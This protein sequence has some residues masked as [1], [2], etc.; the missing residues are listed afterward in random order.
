[1]PNKD[2]ILYLDMDGVLVDFEGGYQRA[3]KGKTFSQ[4]MSKSSE[5]SAQEVYYQRGVHFWSNLD[6]IQ[7]GK[8]LYAAAK[9]LFERVCILSSGGTQDPLKLKVV[10]VGKLLWLEKNMPD[11]DKKD[12]FIVP[13]KEFKQKYAHKASILVD[14]MPVTIKQ[15]NQAGGYGI[16]HHASHYKD[17]IEDLE[18]ISRP[19]KISELAKR[20]KR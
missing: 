20:Y 4:V 17:T 18:D 19:I 5:L 7:G 11:M 3:A 13:G 16:L 15:F 14:D 12:I 6:W 2:Y 1:M 8:E 10:T 9:K